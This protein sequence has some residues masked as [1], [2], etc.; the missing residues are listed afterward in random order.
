MAKMAFAAA[1]FGL[2]Q[3]SMC[4]GNGQGQTV[5]ILQL[6]PFLKGARVLFSREW[7]GL[8]VKQFQLCNWSLFSR[9]QG[10]FSPGVPLGLGLGEPFF[11]EGCQYHFWVGVELGSP[12]LKSFFGIGS[13]GCDACLH[14]QGALLPRAALQLA[15]VVEKANALD[16][17]C[18]YWCMWLAL[19]KQHSHQHGI[20]CH[21]GS[22]Q[23]QCMKETKSTTLINVGQFWSNLINFGQFWSKPWF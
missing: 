19:C 3:K 20:S 4:S 11:S 14:C 6:I 2:W 23:I 13:G 12:S 15:V 8:L 21:C 22:F 17:T 5:S 16:E 1:G 18:F 9:V 7:A 10:C